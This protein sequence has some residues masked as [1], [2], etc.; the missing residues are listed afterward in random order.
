MESRKHKK[1][2]KNE[3]RDYV[4]MYP[5]KGTIMKIMSLDKVLKKL[6]LSVDRPAQNLK[7]TNLLF[8]DVGN[9][10]THKIEKNTE[11]TR[12]KYLIGYED[13]CLSIK[14]I[15][16]NGAEVKSVLENLKPTALKG[17]GKNENYIKQGDY[18]FKPLYYDS[19]RRYWNYLPSCIEQ[20]N[21]KNQI[22]GKITCENSSF[23]NYKLWVK[24]WIKQ[25]GHKKVF[26][27]EWSE[28]LNC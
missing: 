4:L 2:G 27:K 3:L 12:V 23:W 28:S 26:L 18:F 15:S 1:I 20:T 24:G 22:R 16:D 25:D 14:N 11:A 9:K 6:L 19:F 5:G 13:N 21:Y 8:S 17:K 10:E 7:Y